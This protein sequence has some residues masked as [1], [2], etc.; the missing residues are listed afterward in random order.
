MSF[1]NVSCFSFFVAR[2]EQGN[3]LEKTTGVKYTNNIIGYFIS[4]S[5]QRLFSIPAY[6]P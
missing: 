6:C 2:W 4:F 1:E 3:V 5:K